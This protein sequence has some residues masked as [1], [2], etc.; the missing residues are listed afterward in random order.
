MGHKISTVQ[1]V[2]SDD[3][4]KPGNAI[5]EIWFGDVEIISRLPFGDSDLAQ[6]AWPVGGWPKIPWH[7]FLI[8]WKR[9]IAYPEGGSSSEGA[10]EKREDDR[11]GEDEMKTAGIGILGRPLSKTELLGTAISLSLIA[12]VAFYV[13][14]RL[15]NTAPRFRGVDGIE[16]CGGLAR[17]LK[18][19]YMIRGWVATF[20]FLLG[21]AVEVLGFYAVGRMQSLREGSLLL[22]LD[23]IWA[24]AATAGC[25]YS[26]KAVWSL[27]RDWARVRRW[28]VLEVNYAGYPHPLDQE[29]PRAVV[30]WLER[31]RRP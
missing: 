30:S 10:V 14:I 12:L 1:G 11:G 28:E 3:Y 27:W 24:L 21:I 15:R 7:N 6:S 2:K 29:L 19:G 13:P 5:N 8:P 26:A 20:S 31:L 25:F 23:V 4:Y 17:R 18:R 9:S 16:E 22:G